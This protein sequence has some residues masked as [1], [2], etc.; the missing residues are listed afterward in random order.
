MS[1]RPAAPSRDRAMIFQDYSKA[2]LP[3]RNVAGNVAF[4]L[5]AC[6]VHEPERGVEVA[7]LLATIGLSQSAAQYPNQLSGGMHQCVQ[8][9]RCL[10]R[11]SAR[12]RKEVRRLQCPAPAALFTRRFGG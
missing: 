11:Q 6:G 9:A 12:D 10:A 7:A 1:D 5:E 2:L 8:I 4:A 3:W